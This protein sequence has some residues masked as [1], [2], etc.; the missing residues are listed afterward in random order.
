MTGVLLVSTVLAACG[1]SGS[2]SAPPASAGNTT[3]ET[4][5]PSTDAPTTEA[6]TTT[7]P[8]TLDLASLPGLLAIDAQSCGPDPVV[9]D[10]NGTSTDFVICT[11]RPD[12]TGAKQIS[13]PGESPGTPT[14][15][16]DGIHLYYGDTYTNYGWITDLTTG[17]HRER[18]F[19]EPIRAGISPDG[20]MVLTSNPDG[21]GLGIARPDFSAFPD[22]SDFRLLIAD[23]N[24]EGTSWAPDSNHFVYR[25]TSNVAGDPY[26]SELWIGSVDG[27]PPVQITNFGAGPEG[28]LGCPDGVRW[29][30]VGDRI[31]VKMLGQP[32][33][34]AENLYLINSDGTGLTALT[35]GAPITDMNASTYAV[36]GSSYA[37]DWSPDGKYIA[38]IVGDG[39]GYQLA[40]MNSDGGQVTV[41]DNAPLGITTSLVSISW[42]PR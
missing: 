20:T 16:R 40:V 39:T 17:E 26:C 4:T 14:F 32:M 34:T 42:A 6:P 9:D 19:H 28:A 10:G 29:S 38:F 22:G 37:A 24:I 8:A 5:T 3:A 12:G 27:Q 1:G 7:L 21:D 25:S 36:E 30:P 18:V 13:M 33:Y 23:P 11:L 2:S 35:H 15:T 31:L 41:I